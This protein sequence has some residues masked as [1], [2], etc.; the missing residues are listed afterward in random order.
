MG[1]VSHVL[2]RRS[3]GGP[4]GP[5][6][7]EDLEHIVI[8]CFERRYPKQ[9]TV[10]RPKSNILPPKKFWAGYATDVLLHKVAYIFY[11]LS[12]HKV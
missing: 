7:P 5:C 1:K 10:I 4:T 11:P 3:Q 8:L 12:L 9:N 2:H 6:P